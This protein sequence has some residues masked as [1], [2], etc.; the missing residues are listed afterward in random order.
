LLLKAFSGIRRKTAQCIFNQL[1]R[2]VVNVIPSQP[3]Q[4]P[5]EVIVAFC[6][7]VPAETLANI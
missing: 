3:D 6:A 5:D 1:A 2:L 4:Y 7:N